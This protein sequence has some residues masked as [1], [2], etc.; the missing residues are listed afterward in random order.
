M[1]LNESD[2][3]ST[4]SQSIPVINNVKQ[5]PC[6]SLG[7]SLVEVKEADGWKCLVAVLQEK[8]FSVSP[9]PKNIYFHEV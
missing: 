3:N 9:I 2:K 5:Y 1:W 4:N 7:P 8:P 6:L